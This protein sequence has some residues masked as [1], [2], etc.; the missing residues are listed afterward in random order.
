M[1]RSWKLPS[2]SQQKPM[3]QHSGLCS[4]QALVLCLGS[5][6]ARNCNNAACQDDL[7]D[8]EDAEDG[9]IGL[10]DGW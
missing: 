1:V 7:A 5:S 3:K 2:G 8:D 4:L 9:V 6:R 10:H